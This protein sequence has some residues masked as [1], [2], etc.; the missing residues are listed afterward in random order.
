MP[1]FFFHSNSFFAS[2]I[3]FILPCML[4]HIGPRLPYIS[5]LSVSSY[6]HVHYFLACLHNLKH[7]THATACFLH[8]R[9]K[10]QDYS[11]RKRF[12]LAGFLRPH[13]WLKY[14]ICMMLHSK[15][16]LIIFVLSLFHLL[17]V[18]SLSVL[19]SLSR[20]LFIVSFLH[21]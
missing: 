20:V 7:F 6:P 12:A 11:T 3:P 16:K 2:G 21:N 14:S 13:D 15:W 8:G 1:A 4:P 19:S 10:I 5:S 18:I 9:L 17:V